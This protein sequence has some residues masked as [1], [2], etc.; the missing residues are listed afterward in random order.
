MSVMHATAGSTVLS[1]FYY[2]PSVTPGVG[3]TP[4]YY[5]G[6][7]RAGHGLNPLYMGDGYAAAIARLY[8]GLPCATAA[9]EPVDRDDGVEKLIEGFGK[10]CIGKL[11]LSVSGAEAEVA[12]RG[13]GGSAGVLERYEE[14]LCLL[15]QDFEIRARH[16]YVLTREWPKPEC[17][18]SALRLSARLD[19]VEWRKVAYREG[20]MEELVCSSS[21]AVSDP[22]RL[23]SSSST[24]SNADFEIV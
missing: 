20:F 12:G 8:S 11:S 21:R 18:E 15:M 17:E 5:A 23:H 14:N 16:E 10:L 22:I 13:E 4:P 1:S 3:H 19:G 24:E 2:N 6:G 7:G 9:L